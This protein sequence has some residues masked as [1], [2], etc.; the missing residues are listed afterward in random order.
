MIYRKSIPATGRTRF[1]GGNEPIDQETFQRLFER[2]AETLERLCL[3]GNPFLSASDDFR[4]VGAM[5]S[6][7]RLSQLPNVH[8]N[9]LVVMRMDDGSDFYCWAH[10]AAAPD[11]GVPDVESGVE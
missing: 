7:H 6:R 5:A 9:G 11:D 8:L 10:R 3:F 2:P 4:S 1:D